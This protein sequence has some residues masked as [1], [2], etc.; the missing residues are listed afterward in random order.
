MMPAAWNDSIHLFLRYPIP[1][2]TRPG[3]LLGYL[4]LLTA[5]CCWDPCWDLVFYWCRVD[6]YKIIK[7]IILEDLL[8]LA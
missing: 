8:I 3:Y 6:Y 7:K 5:D 2:D 1:A 4:L